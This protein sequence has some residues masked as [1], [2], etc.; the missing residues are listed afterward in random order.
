MSFPMVYFLYFLIGALFLASHDKIMDFD[1]T[2]K[3]NSADMTKR[4][5]GGMPNYLSTHGREC[6]QICK[7]G[8]EKVK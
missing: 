3:G 2:F 8:R 6:A 4:R 1:F 5:A 7:H